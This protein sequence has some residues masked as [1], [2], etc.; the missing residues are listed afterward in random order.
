[1]LDEVPKNVPVCPTSVTG[2][3]WKWVLKSSIFVGRYERVMLADLPAL[4][5][6]FILLSS[7][8]LA[9]LGLLPQNT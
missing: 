6:Q 9:T 5:I 7:A 8:E 1:M 2:L 3:V 4:L